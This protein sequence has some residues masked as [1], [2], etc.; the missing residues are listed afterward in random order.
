MLWVIQ[1]YGYSSNHLPPLL[2]STK[3][4]ISRLTRAVT[5]GVPAS[6]LGAEA[7]YHDPDM[8]R[9]VAHS[10]HYGAAAMRRLEVLKSE[11]DP[12]EVFWNPQSIRPKAN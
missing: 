1:H 10:L 5:A 11:I 2:E 8:A 3:G 9:D 7:N 6:S 12:T 4:L